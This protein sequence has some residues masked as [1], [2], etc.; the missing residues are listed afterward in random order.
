M[1]IIKWILPSF[2]APVRIS[3]INSP[4]KRQKAKLKSGQCF[5][6]G[7]TRSNTPGSQWDVVKFSHWGM[8]SH[9]FTI[10]RRRNA[11]NV[12]W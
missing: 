2:P 4:R 9:T 10:I 1:G 12:R 6:Q 3:I 5:G 8:I 11:C 7:H